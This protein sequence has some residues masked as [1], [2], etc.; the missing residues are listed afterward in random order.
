M[1][2]KIEKVLRDYKSNDE[3]KVAADTTF[4]DLELDSLDTVELIMNL[5]DEFGVTIEMNDEI[6]TV[7][8]LMKAIESAQ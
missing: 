1:L 4:I 6:K 5:E 2:E 8:D 3:L 7:G